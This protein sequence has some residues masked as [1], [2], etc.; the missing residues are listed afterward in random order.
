MKLNDCARATI[1]VRVDPL[2]AFKVFTEQTDA[3]WRHGPK[4]RFGGAN[5]GVLRFECGRSGRIFEKF[6]DGSEFEVGKV[7]V[8]DPGVRLL[9]VWRIPNF[10]PGES[11]EVE[12]LFNATKG[13]TNIV[14]E[15][16][17]WNSLRDDHP[18]RHGLAGEALNTS[19]A[20]WWAELL[21]SLRGSVGG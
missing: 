10:A 14:V 15:H 11:T 4:Y 5:R 6:E 9:F 20:F 8:W 17:G 3:W 2:V 7:V 13:G 19:I 12:I 1:F 18:A 16:R 21:K